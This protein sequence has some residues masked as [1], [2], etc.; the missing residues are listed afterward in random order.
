MKIERL[1]DSQIRCILSEMDLN[2]RSLNLSELAYGSDKARRLFR[3][4]VQKASAEV[5][6]DA[7]DIPLMIEAIP[8][9][10]RSVMLVIT[11]VDDPEE[12]DTRFSR[13]A[14]SPE[15]EF[16]ELGA[17]S[18]DAG[19]E[20]ASPSAAKNRTTAP[21]AASEEPP[22]TTP[23]ERIRIYIF[24]TLD[25]VIDAAKAADAG[26]SLRST[27][28]KNPQNGNY[29]LVLSDQGGDPEVFSSVCN[30]L[31]EYGMRARQNYSSESYYQ[32]HFDVI[33]KENALDSLRKI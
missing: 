2:E 24:Q 31:S 27:L 30:F 11:K 20:G 22:E 14:P 16:P 26:S 7:E 5:G 19:L 28:Y 1:S 6:F 23:Q 21:E 9:S 10:N 13:F 15:G 4:M 12:I 18:F 32:E 29:Y 33:L 17:D 3:E 25:R 8:L